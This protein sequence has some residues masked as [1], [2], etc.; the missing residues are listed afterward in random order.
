MERTS[1]SRKTCVICHQLRPAASY[2][3]QGMYPGVCLHCRQGSPWGLTG[4]DVDKILEEQ[5]GTCAIC[6]R[7]PSGKGA[8]ILVIDHDHHASLGNPMRGLLCQSCNKGLGFFQDS[9]TCLESAIEYLKGHH[10]QRIERYM[11]KASDHEKGVASIVQMM[12]ETNP[13]QR[14]RNQI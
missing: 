14:R 1:N 7:V 6:G 11:A 3:P 12:S 10:Q 9:V 13:P 5:R 2:N 4:N 8:D